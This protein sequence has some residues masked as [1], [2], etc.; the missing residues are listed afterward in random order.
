M[1]GA[2]GISAARACGSSAS[3]GSV[4]TRG[5]VAAHWIVGAHGIAA[6]NGSAAA[7]EGAA[8][9]LAIP[10]TQALAS[11]SGWNGV[12]DPAVKGQD[13][14]WTGGTAVIVRQPVQIYRWLGTHEGTKAVVCWA[15]TTRINF[16]SVYGPHVQHDDLEGEQRRLLDSVKRF[17]RR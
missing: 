2:H 15:R 3:H 14:G 17:W 8:T 1:V 4:T 13:G 7:N 9:H 5:S 11:K 6:A 12:W 10:G 16:V